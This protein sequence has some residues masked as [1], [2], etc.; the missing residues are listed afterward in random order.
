MLLLAALLA[1]AA[2]SCGFAQEIPI[3][4]PISVTKFKKS[5]RMT[6]E[7][8]AG[9]FDGI[10]IHWYQQKEGKA[11]ERLLFFS[12]GKATVDTGFQANRYLVEK[13]S[14]QNWCIL[15]IKDVVPDDAATYYCAYW[16]AH[17]DIH[18]KVVK[19]K[20]KPNKPNTPSLNI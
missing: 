8:R 18:S 20:R 7:I 19:A 9:N 6:C 16:D 15:T 12:A 17:C 1:T 5:A 4:S 13:V 10:V 3:Q 11:P 14:R 2:W